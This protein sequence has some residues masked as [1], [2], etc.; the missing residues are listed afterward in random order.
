MNEAEVKVHV[1]KLLDDL[2]VPGRNVSAV[3]QVLKDAGIKGRP[4]SSYACPVA[5]YLNKH[6]EEMPY[7]VL[8]GNHFVTIKADAFIPAR[9]N[10]YVADVVMPKYVRDFTVKFDW[11]PSFAPELREERN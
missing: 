7:R 2:G 4:A 8:V 10:T 9:A 5:V 3:Y 11:N 1:Q 6:L